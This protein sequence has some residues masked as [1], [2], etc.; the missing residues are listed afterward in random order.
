[1]GCYYEAT[2][3]WFWEN[4]HKLSRLRRKVFLIWLRIM[5]PNS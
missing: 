3:G 5:K 4:R 2:L 1:M